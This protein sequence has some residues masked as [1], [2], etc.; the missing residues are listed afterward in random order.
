MAEAD[1]PYGHFGRAEYDPDNRA[2]S[3]ERDQQT[4]DLWRPLGEP[5]VVVQP[6]RTINAQQSTD[7]VPSHRLP[8]QAQALLKAHPEIQPAFDLLAPLACVSEAV[9]SLA[10]VHDPT[11]GSL[12]SFGLVR[13]EADQRLVEIAAFASGATG[14]DLRLIQIRKQRR[15]WRD[16]KNAWLEMPVVNGEKSTWHGDGAAIRQVCFG[17]TVDSSQNFLAVRLHTKTIVFRPIIRRK[18]LSGTEDSRLDANP[19]LELCWEKTGKVPHAHVS[20]NPWFNRQFGIVDQAGKCNVWEVMGWTD[21]SAECIFTCAVDDDC[22]GRKAVDDG[23]ARILWVGDLMTFAACTRRKLVISSLDSGVTRNI[24]IDVCHNDKNDWL[25]DM[26][27]L[28]YH[29][30][31]LCVLTPTHVLVIL[32]TGD[33]ALATRKV[34]R[35]RHYRSPDD[36]TLSLVIDG[37]AQT[38][39]VNM[40]SQLDTLVTVF[41]LDFDETSSIRAHEVRR[42]DLPN[43]V[44]ATKIAGWHTKMV[45][46]GK[47]ERASNDIRLLKLQEQNV[48]FASLFVLQSDLSMLQALY[49]SSGKADIHASIEPPDWERK[50]DASTPRLRTEG[51]VIDDD[52]RGDL[53]VDGSG[54]RLRPLSAHVQRRIMQTRSAPK[55]GRGWTVNLERAARQLQND[56]VVE[57]QEFNAVLDKAEDLRHQASDVPPVQT[58]AELGRGELIVDDIE[59]ASQRLENLA[60]VKPNDRSQHQTVDEAPV[61]PATR[62][63]LRALRRPLGP[64]TEPGMESPSLMDIYNR[65]VD[66]WITPLPR[67]VPGRVRLAK[68]QLVRRAAAEVALA[69]RIIRTEDVPEPVPTE[70]QAPQP[71]DLPVIGGLS[72]SSQ[73]LI[74]SQ[75]LPES[76]QSNTLP[77]PSVTPSV[78]TGTSYSTT[79]GAPEVSRLSKYTTFSEPAPAGLPRSLN[80]VLSHWDVGTDPAE[81]DWLRSTRQISR[82]QDAED[83]EQVIDEREREKLRRKA[84]RLL[85]RQRR[86]AEASE[87]ARLASSQAPQLASFSRPRSRSQSRPLSQGLGGGTATQMQ[88]QLVAQSSQSLGMPSA[89]QVVPGRFGGRP[90]KKK[91]KQGF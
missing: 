46:I 14:G 9:E 23:W 41:Q 1:L 27:T 74:S 37:S 38:V 56:Q 13:S 88:S 80:R 7:D 26:A 8:R 72:D 33:A 59:E 55:G 28:P 48:Q 84:E 35:L 68:E 50:L 25:L 2:W 29:L 39:T 75:S 83:M 20:F 4:C 43:T 17:T 90:A 67:H 73:H 34:L 12:L 87:A 57:V 89:S 45:S 65:M 15:G 76:S 79:F 21:M 69:S 63:V 22:T 5:K 42:F 62:L 85:R 51:F 86:E 81:Y 6:I 66:D 52:D 53:D 60:L 70:E 40:R 11:V 78:A 10:S 18:A 36:L 49:L 3:F 61:V 30:D 77:T 82:R 16:S 91:R 19:R 44:D 64:L 32:V 71:F 24:D 31:H 54:R 47:R 58:L